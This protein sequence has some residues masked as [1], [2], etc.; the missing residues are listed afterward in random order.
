MPLQK[1]LFSFQGRIRRSQYWLTSIGVI[2]AVLFGYFAVAQVEISE[3]SDASSFESVDF[4]PGFPIVML[5]LAVLYVALV[6]IG[7]ALNVKRWHDRD[8]SGF[9]IFIALVPIIGGIWAL[10]ECGFLDGTQ[11]PNQFG[12]S[13]KGIGGATPNPAT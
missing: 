11:G 7:L 12:P 1:L 13:P 8:K 4:G 3:M 9:W 5:V 10:V 6:W 2:C